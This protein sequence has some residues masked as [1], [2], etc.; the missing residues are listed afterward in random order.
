MP[1]SIEKELKGLIRSG[2]Y[3]L[4]VERTLKSIMLSKV[5]MVIIADNMPKNIRKKIEML[6]EHNNIPLYVFNGT[7]VELGALIGK[8]FKVSA[9]GVIDPGESKILEL[10]QTP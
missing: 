4:G 3:Y 6:T 8:P 5:K 7:S 9:I 1:V 2:K 10:Y